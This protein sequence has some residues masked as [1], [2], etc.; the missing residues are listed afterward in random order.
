MYYWRANAAND[1]GTSDWSVVWSFRTLVTS[2]EVTLGIPAEFSL[3]QNYP[4]PFNPSTVIRYGLPHRS[5]VTLET[6][7]HIGQRITVLLDIDQEAGYH[8]VVFEGRGL[9]TGVY[10]YRLRAGDFTETR[11][12]VLLR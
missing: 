2:V 8:T 3:S 1:A 4:N 10:F 9:A 5:H 12:L 7:D 6:F 11:K